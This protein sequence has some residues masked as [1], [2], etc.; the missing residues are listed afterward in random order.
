MISRARSRGRQ[1]QVRPQPGRLDESDLSGNITDEYVF[2]GGKRVAHRTVSSGNIYYYAEDFIGSSRVIIQAGQTSVC[3]DADF[4]PFGGERTITN[5]CPQNYKFQGKER[6]TETGNDDFGARYYS[7]SFGRWLSPDWSAVPAPVP[8]A[9]LTNPQTLNL[10][11]FVKNDPETFTDVDGH[12]HCGPACILDQGGS[13]SGFADVEAGSMDVTNMAPTQEQWS[14]TITQIG[15]TDGNADSAGQTGAAQKAQQKVNEKA[16]QM[17][18]AQLQNEF[19]GVIFDPHPT[20]LG[21][22]N[23]HENIIASASLI[24]EDQKNQIKKTLDANKGLFGTRISIQIGTASWSLHVVSNS[25]TAKGELW[26]VSLTAHID[27]G[28]PNRDLVGMAT[29]SFSDGLVGA[30]FHRH[31]PGLDPQ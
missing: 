1:R 13:S 27:R 15:S 17:V 11:Q 4:Y 30:L 19:P 28:N 3:Y 20:D 18:F 31:D 9:D 5:N 14:A 16:A 24:T 10:Y 26:N 12:Y 25:F 2:F 8:Y 21:A 6:D 29:H 23:G 22:H 7:S